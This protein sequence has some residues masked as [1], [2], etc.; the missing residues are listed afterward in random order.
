MRMFLKQQI[1][2][3]VKKNYALVVPTK[4]LI[5]EVRKKVT[6]DLNDN[7]HEFQYHIIT[8]AGDAALES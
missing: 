7:L 6:E 8:A 4:A 5:N 2:S 1:M 3:G